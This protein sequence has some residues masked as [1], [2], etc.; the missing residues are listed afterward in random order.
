MARFFKHRLLILLMGAGI[1]L[2]PPRADA[3]FSVIVE[4]F[5]NGSSSTFQDNGSTGVIQLGSSN[6]SVSNAQLT[7]SPDIVAT[8][9]RTTKAAGD[10]GVVALNTV[11]LKNTG[12]TTQTFRIS[13]EDDGFTT[14]GT[15][16][17]SMVA[18]IGTQATFSGADKNTP[19]SGADKVSG[20]TTAITFSKADGS[21]K[22]VATTPTISG[23]IMLPTTYSNVHF[24]REDKYDIVT[25][26]TFTLAAHD[27]V[28]FSMTGEVA[29]APA[30]AGLVLLLIGVASLGVGRWL[31]RRPLRKA[32]AA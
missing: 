23:G 30:P 21:D 6:T 7:G 28:T 2:G 1:S 26:A 17:G 4:N 19:P 25:Q 20:V 14:P 22:Q 16:G 11:T 31:V 13:I 18:E 8:S 15:T 12:T 9:N 32:V 5:S 24:T 29:Q 3:G 10:A 27:S